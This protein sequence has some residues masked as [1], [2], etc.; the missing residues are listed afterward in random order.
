MSNEKYHASLTLGHA[1]LRCAENSGGSCV[2]MGLVIAIAVLGPGTSIR[3]I[4]I[5][6]PGHM[7]LVTG[8]TLVIL[9]AGVS[10]LIL[11]G[12]VRQL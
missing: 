10:G 7:L 6:G 11:E 5:L 9:G 3:V 4:S 2:D 8:T 12:F 1:V